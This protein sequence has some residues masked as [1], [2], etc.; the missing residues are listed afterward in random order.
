MNRNSST[1]MLPFPG[2]LVLLHPTTKG[3]KTPNK[4]SSLYIHISVRVTQFMVE[5]DSRGR[6]PTV[7]RN[8]D[9][10]FCY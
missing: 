8:G 1:A 3:T 6:A 10:L 9:A 4:D 5:N 2:T 7:G